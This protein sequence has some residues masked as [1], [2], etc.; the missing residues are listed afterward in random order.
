MQPQVWSAGADLLW[1]EKCIKIQIMS[2]WTTIQFAQLPVSIFVNKM[3][4]HVSTCWKQGWII[5]I[6]ENDMPSNRFTNKWALGMSLL[7]PLHSALVQALASAPQQGWMRMIGQK[8]R[9]YIIIL[10]V[11]I[12]KYIY[13]T[14]YYIIHHYTTL[15]T[16]FQGKPILLS[17]D[18][19]K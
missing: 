10:Y 1:Y 14:E 15:L 18:I 7:S 3:L 2:N 12:I 5:M 17:Q 11:Y 4:Q 13:T 19:T 8:K 9:W 16:I 6:S